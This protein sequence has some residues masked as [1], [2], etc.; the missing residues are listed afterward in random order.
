MNFPLIFLLLTVTFA[1]P[2]LVR[3][4]DARPN[5]GKYEETPRGKSSFKMNNS[6]GSCLTG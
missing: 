5:W 2:D 3:K 6:S 1:G 4:E